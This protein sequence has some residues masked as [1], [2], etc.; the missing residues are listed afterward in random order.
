[1]QS[2]QKHVLIDHGTIEDAA[3]SCMLRLR[4]NERDE[5][6]TV[7]RE[8]RAVLGQVAQR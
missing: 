5:L 1:M 4:A 7:A 3:D 2:V 8:P 6:L